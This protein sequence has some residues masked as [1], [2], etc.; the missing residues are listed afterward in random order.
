MKFANKAYYMIELRASEAA[1]QCIV[2]ALS[3]CLLVCLFVGLLP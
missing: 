2:I 3:V 1:A